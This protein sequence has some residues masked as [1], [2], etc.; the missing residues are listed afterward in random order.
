MSISPCSGE[1]ETENA[2]IFGLGPFGSWRVAIDGHWE[3][4][5][6]GT[7]PN[8]SARSGS[9]PSAKKVASQVLADGTVARVRFTKYSLQLQG[10]LM[11]KFP[12]PKLEFPIPNGRVAEF[13]TTYL[14]ADGSLRAARGASGNL[15]FF[16]RVAR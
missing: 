1:L 8:P 5:A 3:V 6:S 14:S 4:A 11:L 13:I 7:T 2:A 12:G 15:F 9:F 10:F 16:R